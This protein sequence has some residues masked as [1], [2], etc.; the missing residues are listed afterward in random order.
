M[1]ADD[2]RAH[3]LTGQTTV[4]RA[5]KVMRRDGETIGFT[6]HDEG[7]YFEETE[8]KANSGLTAKALQQ[9]TGLSVDNTE[10]VGALTD[11]A[12]REEDI[13][14]GRYDNAAV[15]AFLVNW[16]APA[17][18]MVL[19]RGTF[20]EIRRSNGSFIVELRGLS[21]PLNR[22]QG[23]VYQSGCS[24]R[25]GDKN[26]RIDLEQDIFRLEASLSRV[27]AATG[28]ELSIL[29]SH[30]DRWFD[31]GTLT[32]LTGRAQGLSFPIGEDRRHSAGRQITLRQGFV[33][34]PEP[35]DL[36]RLVVGCDGS[37]E[38]CRNRFGNFENFR[39]FPHIPGDDWLKRFPTSGAG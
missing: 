19:F 16:A 17:M 35:G 33:I 30:P 11:V 38:T 18:R 4:C 10:A 20:G 1:S 32:V 7:L 27:A 6:D 22:Q 25:L 34:G 2:L 28:L 8:F 23:R 31:L 13:L 26:C 39:G 36:V 5:W 15:T 29:S 9:A 24:A 21:E 12:V 37:A 3:L 14:A